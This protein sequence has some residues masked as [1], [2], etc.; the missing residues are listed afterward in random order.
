MLTRS[1]TWLITT[2]LALMA[3]MALGATLAAAADLGAGGTEAPPDM[4]RH[5]LSNQT[6]LLMVRA[7]F[8]VVE[9]DDIEAEMVALAQR[10]GPSGPSQEVIDALDRTLLAEASYFLVSL[11]YTTL[12]DGAVWPDDKPEGTYTNDA[13]VL[14]ES[15][16]RQLDD[17]IATGRDPL[18]VL[19]QLQQLWLLSE[20][21]KDVPPERDMFANRDEIVA[22][23]LAAQTPRENV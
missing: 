22:Q 17:A 4:A 19:Q 2:L 6:L 16:E 20:G 1:R 23:A 21:M 5:Y 3:L 14:L 10:L 9:R 13:I 18:P 15:L 7:T 12:V 11:R 8:D